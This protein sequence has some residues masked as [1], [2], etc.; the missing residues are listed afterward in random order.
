MIYRIAESR[1]IEFLDQLP[2]PKAWG[3]IVSGKFTDDLIKKHPIND[4]GE[5]VLNSG[6]TLSKKGFTDK[7]RSRFKAQT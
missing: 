3:L 2:A 6:E 1:G 5:L 4:K 7:Y